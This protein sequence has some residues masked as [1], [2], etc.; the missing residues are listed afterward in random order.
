[1]T[2][3]PTINKVVDRLC[4]THTELERF[5]INP[6]KAARKKGVGY[7]TT[8]KKKSKERFPDHGTNLDL[9]GKANY[10]D[11]RFCGLHP[12]SIGRLEYTK[13]DLKKSLE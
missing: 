9:S 12:E 3:E 1:M 11:P 5:I 10:L 7:A 4:T 2:K 8:L 13:D 6:E